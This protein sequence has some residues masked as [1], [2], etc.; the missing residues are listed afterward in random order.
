MTE[1]IYDR[2]RI[3]VGDE[4]IEKL[5]RARVIVCGCGA[6]GGYVIEGLVRA[7]VGKLRVV[8]KDVFS[9][10]NLNRQVLCTGETIGRVKSEVACERARL[11]NP[12]I[13]IEGMP[14]ETIRA[15]VRRAIDTYC[16]RGRF[17][18]G[19]PAGACYIPR[20]NEIAN[21]ELIKYGK[22]YVDARYPLN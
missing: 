13:D 7:G 18:P 4:G 20:N 22:A 17:Y 21:D 10:S 1:T 16:E 9:E 2:T 19:M 6:V 5:R 3:L 8:D 14:E 11:I 12:G 15:E